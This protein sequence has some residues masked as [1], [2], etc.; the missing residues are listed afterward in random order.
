M[1]R[2]AVIDI[3]T[4]SIKFILAEMGKDGAF[5]TLMDKNNI[6]KLGE[7]L[8]ETGLISP[9]AMA[10]NCDAIKEFADIARSEGA[11]EIFAVGTMAL[12]NAKNSADFLEMVEKKAG[13]KVRVIPGEEEAQYSYLAVVSGIDLGK[14]KLAIIDTGGGST[15]FVFGEGDSLGRRFSLDLGA[16][17]VTEEFLKSD[18]VKKEEVE[19]AL[20]FID[21]FLGSNGVSGKVDK[22]VGMGGGITSMGSVM[23]EMV[24]Y[25]PDRIQGSFLSL[26]EVDR[27]IAMYSA[28][29]IEERRAVVGLQPK[30][31]D[32][33]LASALIV[34]AIMHR[35]GVDGLTISDR[36]LR[37]GLL[38]HVGKSVI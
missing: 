32:V 4:N 28:K 13:V 6:A 24:D 10:R 17:R 15:E 18:P 33:I 14:G 5:K 1:D 11:S 8:K 20:S 30:R 27:Q 21:G 36:G 37:H 2:K 25:D 34:K 35:L 31:A 19:K 38:Y 16:I 12:R 9:D 23:F 26:K 7:G 3:G 29:T 22:L